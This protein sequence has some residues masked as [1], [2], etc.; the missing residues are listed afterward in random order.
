MFKCKVNAAQ[1]I[2]NISIVC[3]VNWLEIIREISELKATSSVDIIE[4]IYCSKS[5]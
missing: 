5:V 1:D 2:I 3:S 4:L